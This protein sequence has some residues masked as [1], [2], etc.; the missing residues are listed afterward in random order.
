MTSGST[1]PRLALTSAL[2]ASLVGCVLLVSPKDYGAHCRFEGEQTPC[3]QCIRTRC[4]ADVDGCCGQGSCEPTLAAVEACAAGD[5]AKCDA[6]ASLRTSSEAAKA[7]VG[8]C[9]DERCRDECSAPSARNKTKC[10]FPSFGNGESCSCTLA[11]TPND[12]TCDEAVLP[13][14]ICCAPQGWP[15][16]GLRCACKA[17]SCG[18][19][20]DGCRCSLMDAPSEGP[21]CSAKICCALNDLCTCGSSTCIAGERKVASCARAEL[22]C[23][24]GLM[25]VASCVVAA[26]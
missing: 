9:L 21:S 11:T 10:S 2:A 17:V 6:V 18:A 23:A 3:G 14:A 15:A 5:V 25:R 13:K 20:G 1:L 4:E 8:R 26:P 19:T 16:D 7:G 12:V 24:P 22:A